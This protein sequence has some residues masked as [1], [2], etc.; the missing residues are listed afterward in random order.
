[1][2]ERAVEWED[3]QKK[4]IKCGIYPNLTYMQDIKIDLDKVCELDNI[5]NV[6]D[7]IRSLFKKFLKIYNSLLKERNKYKEEL[8]SYKNNVGE[9]RRSALEKVYKY[10]TVLDAVLIKISEVMPITI[11]GD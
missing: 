3:W 10:E 5:D 6:K 4:Q 8:D 1:M 9:I 2:S 11:K 7:G